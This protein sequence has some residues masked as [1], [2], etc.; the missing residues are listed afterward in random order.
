MLAK[1]ATTDPDVGL[2]E[3]AVWHLEDQALVSYIALTDEAALV[4]IAAIVRL[5]DLGTLRQ[6]ATSRAE[7]S[8]FVRRAAEDRLK[9][10][11]AGR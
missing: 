5:A 2:R 9:E 6:I 8:W 7:T 10:L 4:R 11:Q 3:E 1:V